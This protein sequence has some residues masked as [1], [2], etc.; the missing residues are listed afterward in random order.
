MGVFLFCPF[1]SLACSVNGVLQPVGSCVVSISL[2]AL[3]MGSPTRFRESVLLESLFKKKKLGKMIQILRT[4]PRDRVISWSLICQLLILIIINISFYYKV[5]MCLVSV[6]LKQPY[7]TLNIST[8][9]FTYFTNVF[10]CVV[11]LPCN[12]VVNI[13]TIYFNCNIKVI[14]RFGSLQ[15]LLLS[16]SFVDESFGLVLW[17][18]S[19]K[20]SDSKERFLHES[21]IAK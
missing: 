20:R 2:L 8:F 19:T 17:T 6:V 11:K 5:I 21:D 18:G 12:H 7:W 13:S 16:V 10:A 14:L 3:V 9:Y 15:M 4:L 1:A